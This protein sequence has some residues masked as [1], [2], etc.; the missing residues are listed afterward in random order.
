MKKE[1]AFRPRPGIGDVATE[2]R[3][4][5]E[6]INANKM[7]TISFKKT[8]EEHKQLRKEKKT[9][10]IAMKSKNS[11]FMAKHHKFEAKLTIN[12]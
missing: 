10:R 1:Q 5:Q 3:K 2:H 7:V 4:L 11:N 9:W 12:G 8:P 6:E